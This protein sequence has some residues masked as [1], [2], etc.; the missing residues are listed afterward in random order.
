MFAMFLA[1]LRNYSN[2]SPV[3]TALV[4]R[5]DYL[6]DWKPPISL[7]ARSHLPIWYEGFLGL[8][9]DRQRSL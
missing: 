2:G 8:G 6:R 5:S 1:D 3:S 9:L 7:L 4:V